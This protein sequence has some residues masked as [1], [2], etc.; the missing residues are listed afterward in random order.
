VLLGAGLGLLFHSGHLLTAFGVALAPG[1][2]ATVLTMAAKEAV[3]A[4]SENP[5]DVLYLV[6]TPNVLM[7]VLAAGVLAHL[8]WGLASPVRLRNRLRSLAGGRRPA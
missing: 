6:W 2:G 3:G 5:E 7:L 8:V 4:H 1:L